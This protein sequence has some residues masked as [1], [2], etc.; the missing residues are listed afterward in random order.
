MKQ[1]KSRWNVATVIVF[2]LIAVGLVTVAVYSPW[3]FVFPVIIV[4]ILFL[5]YKFPP[6]Q[7][8]VKS[9]AA[10]PKQT[11]NTGPAR[12]NGRPRAKTVPFRVIEGGKDDDD[13]PRY[14]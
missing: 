7:T 3:S 5:L 1:G 10:K 2:A 12:Q 14:H 6:G 13:V 4:G 9:R 11:K 8:R